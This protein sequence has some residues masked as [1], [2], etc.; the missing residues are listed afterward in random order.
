MRRPRPPQ[1]GHL[2]HAESLKIRNGVVDFVADAD[3]NGLGAV[4]TLKMSGEPW[5]RLYV[6]EAELADLISSGDVVVAG[7][8]D[9][10]VALLN[11]FETG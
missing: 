10:A 5:Q 3:S 2:V 6:N 7:N 11:L 9:Q 1:K 4:A 8:A